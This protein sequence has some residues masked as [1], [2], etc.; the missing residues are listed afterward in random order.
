[1]REDSLPLVRSLTQPVDPRPREGVVARLERARAAVA[2]A[3]ELFIEASPIGPAVLDQMTVR[4]SDVRWLSERLTTADE[5]VRRAIANLTSRPF[6]ECV[7]GVEASA[8]RWAHEVGKEARVVV[9]GRDVRVPERIAPV[10][11]AMLPHIVR[12]AIAHGIEAPD[13]R[14]SSGKPTEGTMQVS[15]TEEGARLVIRI[16]DDGSGLDEAAIVA[17]ARRLGFRTGA[18]SELL[19]SAGVSTAHQVD[20]LAGQGIGMW[21][22]REGLRKIGGD[23]RVCSEKGR[24]AEFEITAPY[25]VD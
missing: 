25:A 24:G 11:R 21:A 9:G 22:V 5:D 17:Q 13:K 6:G 14:R 7:T 2:R 19:F 15:A 23:I 10:L 1:M 4:K 16:R 8:P 3:R 12:N 18:A 20:E